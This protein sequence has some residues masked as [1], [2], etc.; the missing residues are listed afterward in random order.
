MRYVAIAL[1]ILIVLSLGHALR[2]VLRQPPGSRGAVRALT[3]RI[4]LSLLLFGLLWLGA[5]LGWWAPHGP[6]R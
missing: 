5:A 3:A 4:A 1:L 6:G 2:R